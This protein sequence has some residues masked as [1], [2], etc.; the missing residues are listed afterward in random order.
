MVGDTGDRS[1]RASLIK[2]L[3]GHEPRP[4]V[5]LRGAEALLPGLANAPYTIRVLVENGLRAALQHA[6]LDI[7]AALQAAR[8]VLGSGTAAGTDGDIDFYPTR[9]VLQDHSGIPVLLDLASLRASVAEGGGDVTAVTPRLRTDLVTDHSVEAHFSGP[10]ALARNRERELRLNEDRYRFL[11]WALQAFPKLNVVPPGRGIVHQINLEHFAEVVTVDRHG[12]LAP[13]TLIGTDSHTPMINALGVLGW[14]VGGIEATSVLMGRPVSLSTP[15]V[16]G[17]RLDGRRDRRTYATDVALRLAERLRQEDVVGQIIEFFGP[18][19]E[20]LSVPDRATIANMA[21]EYGCTAAVFPVDRATIAY[22]RATGRSPEQ[23]SL[24]QAYCQAQG[25][26]REEAEPRF[27]RLI[28]VDLSKIDRTVS[29]PSRPYQTLAL[30]EVPQSLDPARRSLDWTPTQARPGHGAVALAAIASCTNTA[31]LDA[32]LAAGLLARRA[33]ARGLKPPAW[34]RPSLSPGSRTVTTYLAKTGL[35]QDLAALGFHTVGYGCMTCIGNSGPLN[36]AVKRLIADGV[37]AVAILSGNR[38]FEGRIHADLSAAY[39]AS[40]PLVVAYA[41]AGTVARDLTREPL[42]YDPAGKPVMLDDLWPSADDVAGF[43]QQLSPEIFQAERRVI[44]ATPKDWVTPPPTGPLYDWPAAS[45]YVRRPPAAHASDSELRDIRGA[46]ALLRLGD[47]VTTD[48][49]SPAGA[50]PTASPAGEYLRGSGVEPA[51]FNTYGC[52]R[53]NHEVMILGAFS[54]RRIRNLLAPDLPGGSTLVL[55]DRLQMTIPDAARAYRRRGVPVIVIA[56]G[57]YGMG[58]SRDW[59]ARAQRHLGVRAVL[60]EGFERIHR[61]NLIGMGVA[62]LEFLEPGGA[63]ALGITGAER[64]DIVGLAE[65]G[66]AG[67]VLVEAF[68]EDNGRVVQWPMRLRVDTKAELACLHAGGF[69]PELL[70]Q[71]ASA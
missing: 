68:D 11:G 24:V 64:F 38:N 46:R 21:P 27:S 60:A 41:L 50:I 4:Y 49:I 39:L 55:P 33:V 6:P 56:G 17:V 51:E 26:L 34:V 40:P 67:T 58:S 7:D 23:V 5:C 22:L 54:N 66:P 9:V 42:G 37:E 35:L 16:V 57:Q 15:R 63:A 62:P 53:G 47:A 28:A 2:V 25:L 32:M 12:Y 61:S 36:P 14:G 30:A 10:S 70:D 45:T 1:A 59:A 13:D 29:G 65:A 44:Y 43:H 18:G 19:L 31:N 71:F 3:P 20:H 48:H 8:R 69:L 52:R